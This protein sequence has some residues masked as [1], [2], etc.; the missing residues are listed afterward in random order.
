MKRLNLLALAALTATGVANADIIVNVNPAI[1]QKDF[2]IEY[3]YISDIAKPRAE[4]PD[5]K[6][7]ECEVKNGSFIIPIL[8]SGA[9]QYR[10]PTGD[11]ERVVIYTHPNDELTVNLESISPLTYSVSGSQLMD[12]I[13]KLKSEA[14]KIE[15]KYREAMA[16]G[17]P[18][19]NLIR[20]LSSDYNDIFVNYISDNPTAEAVAYAMLNIDDNEAFMQIYNGLTPEALSG[21]LTPFLEQQKSYIER[22]LESEKKRAAL[23]SGSVDAP[24]FTFNDVNGKPISLSQFKGKWVIIDFWGTWC[25]WCIKGF[26]ALKEAYAKYFDKL[27][28]VG[29][30]CNERSEEAWAAGVKRHE[31]PWVNIYNPEKGGGELLKNYA[32]EGF[33]TKA[34]VNPEGKIVNITVGEDPNFFKILEDL[35]K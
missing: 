10:I 31:L 28:V 7:M 3:G 25:P 14:G 6:E 26:P 20:Q 8:E 21:P 2:K 16:G 35:L 32:V 22:S 1:A 23:Q 17:N 27:E 33:P 12:D 9:A 34:I 11:R 15:Q 19:E 24:D 18:D 4:R 29:V 13:T 30:A 5:P